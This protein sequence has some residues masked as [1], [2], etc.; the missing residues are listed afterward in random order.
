M[1]EAIHRSGARGM[2]IAKKYSHL[3][4]EEWLL[5]HEKDTYQELLDVIEAIDAEQCRT[6]VSREKQM[7][8]RLLFG[9]KD[10]NTEFASRLSGLGWESKRYSYY[11]AHNYDQAEVMINLSLEEQKQHLLNQGAEVILSY[12]QT[13]HVKHSIAIEVQFGKY[14]FVAYDLFVKH[15]LFYTG[16]IINVGIEILPTKAMQ[17]EMSSGIAYYEGEVYNLLRH[18]RNNPPVPLLVIGV[19]PE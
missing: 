10:L 16:R 5:V 7:K 15:L 3:N 11:I 2:R 6:K 18:G 13:D 17:R 8:G 19:E 1:A 4:G 12:N 14:A 9:P